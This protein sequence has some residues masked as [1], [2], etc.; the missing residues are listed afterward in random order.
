MDTRKPKSWKIDSFR[1]CL[2][3]RWEQ[4]VRNAA[5]LFAEI[6]KRGSLRRSGS[7]ATEHHSSSGGH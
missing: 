5:R 7:A 3:K 1:V 4:G 6:R 2:R